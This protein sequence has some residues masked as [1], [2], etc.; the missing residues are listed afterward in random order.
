MVE[1]DVIQEATP[2]KKHREARYFYDVLSW[3]LGAAAIWGVLVIGLIIVMTI[4]G[5]A[6]SEHFLISRNV[7]NILRQLLIA[8]FIVP[9][10]VMVMASGGVDLSAGAVIGLTAMVI[11]RLSQDGTP[12]G[13]AFILVMFVALLVGLVNGLLVGVARIHAVLVTLGT[14]F[15]LEGIGYIVY[16]GIPGGTPLAEEAGAFLDGLG[17]SSVSWILLILQILVVFA[18]LQLTPF[19]RRPKPEDNGESWLA[20]SFFVGTPYILSSLAA[21][22][23]G[24]LYLGRV[25]FAAPGIGWEMGNDAIL[26]AVLGGNLLGGGFGN[27]FTGILGAALVTLLWNVGLLTQIEG[28]VPATAGL[29]VK[30]IAM[31]VIALVAHLYYKGVGWLFRRAK[32][33]EAAGEG[34]E[35]ESADS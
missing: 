5:G 35:S 14:M 32:A 18:L 10:M 30:G 25:R 29:I 15:L 4:F 12:V 27:V 1:N 26:A 33:R 24:A 11:G 7:E 21:A 3:R 8:A 20:R 2:E 28:G 9:P 17:T 16:A 13:L 34:A 19:G 22:Y 6:L 23:A 31:L